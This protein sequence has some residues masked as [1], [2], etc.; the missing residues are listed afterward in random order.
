MSPSGPCVP[1]FEADAL[2]LCSRCAA[3]E[4]FDGLR[5]DDDDDLVELGAGVALAVPAAQNWQAAHLQNLL[6]SVGLQKAAH[7]L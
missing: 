5:R 1:L 7:D 6:Q 3:S 2:E 4:P